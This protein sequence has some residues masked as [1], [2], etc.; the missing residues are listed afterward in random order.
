MTTHGPNTPAYGWK[1]LTSL[2]KTIEHFKE[3]ID[4]FQVCWGVG[5]AE[6]LQKRIEETPDGLLLCLDEFSQFVSKSIIK[7]SVLLPCVN[8]LFE[9]NQ[10]ENRT[11]KEK[12]KLQNAHLS[13]L[14]ASTV[15]TYD[16]TW[17]PAFTDI[18]FTNRIFLVPGTAKRMHS[19]P[20]R[21]SQ[22]E[23]NLMLDKLDSVLRHVGRGMALEITEPAKVIYHNWY[24]NMER[25]IHAKRL[26]TYAVRLMS[27]LAVNELKKEID[28]DIVNKVIALC[29]WQLN[30]RKI[31]DPIDADNKIAA[32]EERIRR[33]LK[34]GQKKIGR[35]KQVVNA[36]RTGLWFFE[37]ALKNLERYSEIALNNKS[38]KW[39]LV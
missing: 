2:K 24:M 9:S 15:Q 34:K 16:R 39:R 7:G 31:H 6:G 14:A 37:K 26:D 12:V 4:D 22:Q 27:L 35:L 25:S 36:N 23:N 20:S 17:K 10:Y 3:C 11:K 32:L 38:K 28:V 8:T 19:L 1:S 30:V 33:A 5:S 13:M 21:I 29:D 18:G